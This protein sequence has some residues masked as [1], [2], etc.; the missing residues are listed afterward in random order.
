MSSGSADQSATARMV[1]VIGVLVVCTAA[2]ATPPPAIAAPGQHLSGFHVREAFSDR[3]DGWNDHGAEI[4]FAPGAFR[5]DLWNHGEEE[6]TRT[7]WVIPPDDR[8]RVLWIF[9]P[10]RTFDECA[11]ETF[12]Q[13]EGGPLGSW[14]IAAAGDPISVLPADDI[15]PV[16]GWSTSAVD[17]REPG[18][19]EEWVTSSSNPRQ[20]T[21][22]TF[23]RHIG[24]LW[25]TAE[26]GVNF[27][28]VRAGLT[29]AL[30]PY[31]AVG[32]STFVIHSMWALT[33]LGLDQDRVPGLPTGIPV[34]LELEADGQLIVTSELRLIERANLPTTLFEPPAGYARTARCLGR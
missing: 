14:P 11:I 12:A 4:W 34:A 31:E 7:S 1:T 33:I 20:K 22:R 16:G 26:T 25:F 27:D 8:T 15:R 5:L 29:A 13:V 21:R 10:T 18:P 30:R 24:R 17:L 23:H 6:A 28:A 2:S 3:E 19:D 9:H 32:G